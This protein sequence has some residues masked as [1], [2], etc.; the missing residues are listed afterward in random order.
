MSGDRVLVICT[1]MRLTGRMSMLAW[2][3]SAEGTC[4]Q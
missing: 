4:L 2:E 3:A 1:A